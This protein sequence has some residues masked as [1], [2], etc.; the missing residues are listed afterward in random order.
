MEARGGMS[1]GAVGGGGGGLQEVKRRRE[2]EAWRD[3]R[4]EEAVNVKEEDRGEKKKGHLNKL[5]RGEKRGKEARG[6]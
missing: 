1:K 5:R 6:G 4:K 2:K 3:G